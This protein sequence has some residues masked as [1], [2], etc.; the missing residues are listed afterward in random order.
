[1]ESIKAFAGASAERQRC[2]PRDAAYLYELE[3]G[4]LRKVVRLPALVGGEV[5]R[6]PLL[7]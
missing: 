4:V 7:I 6:L 1:M 5:V 3:P 2:Y